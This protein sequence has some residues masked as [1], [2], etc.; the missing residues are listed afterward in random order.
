MEI[1]KRKKTYIDYSSMMQQLR[2]ERWNKVCNNDNV[3][4]N[5]RVFIQKIKLY[6]M[7]NT[8]HKKITRKNE[9]KKPWITSELIRSI[10]TKNSM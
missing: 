5:I 8:Q 10:N 3:D 9:G 2:T 1:E 7:Q 6:I 4:D